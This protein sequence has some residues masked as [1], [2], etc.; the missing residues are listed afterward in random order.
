MPGTAK[1][2]WHDGSA[3]DARYSPTPLINEP[4]L[5]F[6]TLS[7][8]STPVTT[9]PAPEDGYVAVLQTTVDILYVVRRPGETRDATAPEAK[10]LLATGAGVASIGLMPGFTISIMEA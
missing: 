4:E 6:E 9:G 2:W 8:S 3:R 7:I 10:P 1:L 5:G